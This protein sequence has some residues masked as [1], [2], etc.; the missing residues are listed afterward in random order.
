[1]PGVTV[2]LLDHDT[3]KTHNDV[4]KEGELLVKSDSLFTR[5]LNNE[6]ATKESITEDGF[7]KTGDSAIISKPF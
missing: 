7:Y 5:Y 1:M 3:G 6:K 4:L 2:K